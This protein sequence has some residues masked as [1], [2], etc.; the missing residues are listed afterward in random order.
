MKWPSVA[1]GELAEIVTGKTPSTA[2]DANFGGGI[3]FVTPADLESGGP[4]LTTP[5]TLTELGASN[6]RLVPMNSVLVG[7]IGTLGKV[8]IAGKTL[9]TNQQINAVVFDP[10]KVLARYGYYAVQLLKPEM[11][12]IAPATTVK[13]VSKSKFSELKI[14]LPPLGEQRRIAGILDQADALRRLRARALDKLNTLGQAIFHEMFGDPKIEQDRWPC[15]DFSSACTDETSKSPK[16]QKGEYLEAG[17]IPVI[18]QGQKS[19]AGFTNIENVCNSTGPVIIFGDHTRAVKYVDHE[20]AIGADGAKVLKPAE[21][22]DPVF[23]AALMRSLPIPDLGYSRHMR[24]VKKLFFACPPI[25]LQRS[26]AGKMQTLWAHEKKLNASQIELLHLFT[27]LQ[28]RAFG[29]DL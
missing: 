9:A 24:E 15:V 5:R 2:D 26:Y 17:D 25:E 16:V 20:F 12:L 7:C 1:L 13:I 3:P 10:H 6:L 23:F 28:H 29:G 18:D 19:I 27:S 4:I 21:Q 22:F 14:P 8:G 11:E